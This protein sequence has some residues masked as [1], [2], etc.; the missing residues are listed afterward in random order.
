MDQDQVLP[1]VDPRQ[2]KLTFT[3]PVPE[4]KE[5]AIMACGYCR[6][7]WHEG[8]FPRHR[9]ECSRPSDYLGP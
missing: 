3:H 9:E 5:K 7:W 6:G 8:E 1:P 2:L 4:P